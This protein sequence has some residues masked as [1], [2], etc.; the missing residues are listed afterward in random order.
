MAW[1]LLHP[2]HVLGERSAPYEGVIRKQLDHT[3]ASGIDYEFGGVY[4]EGPHNG[5]AAYDTEKE[6]WQQAE[7]LVGMLDGC[8]LFGMDPDWKAYQK[9]HRFVFDSVVNREV[10]A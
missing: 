10:G 3:V 6:F 7:T 8:V 2:L 4:V 1:L 9:V 5:G